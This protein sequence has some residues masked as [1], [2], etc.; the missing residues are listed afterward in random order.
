M[1]KSQKMHLE[2]TCWKISFQPHSV[3]EKTLAMQTL[4][5]KDTK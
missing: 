5:Y 2:T 4:E 3:L 1:V